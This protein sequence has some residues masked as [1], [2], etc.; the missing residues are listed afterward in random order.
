MRKILSVVIATLVAS[1]P[2]PAFPSGGPITSDYPHVAQ[3]CEKGNFG[4]LKKFLKNKALPPCLDS[5]PNFLEI[6]E[7]AQAAKEMHLENKLPRLWQEFELALA[8]AKKQYAQASDH[9]L[10]KQVLE[11]SRAARKLSNLASYEKIKNLIIAQCSYACKARAVKGQFKS[12]DGYLYGADESVKEFVN[13]KLMALNNN[14]L[15]A[16]KQGD[17]KAVK[18]Y[19]DKGATPTCRDAEGNTL[20]HL[21]V[22]SGDKELLKFVISRSPFFLLSRNN[23]GEAALHTACQQGDV[24]IVQ[25]LVR[26]M[27]DAGFSTLLTDYKNNNGDTPLHYAAEKDHLEIVK[28]FTTR[29]PE[30]AFE[31][32]GWEEEAPFDRCFANKNI[33]VPIYWLSLNPDYLTGTWTSPNNRSSPACKGFSSGDT[34]LHHAAL[35]NNLDLAQWLVERG[36]RISKKNDL[37]KTPFEVAADNDNRAIVTYFVHRGF[38]NYLPLIKKTF[39]HLNPSCTGT[40]QFLEESLTLTREL[41]KGINERNILKVRNALENGA[42]PNSADGRNCTAIGL[43]IK[44]NFQEAIEELIAYGANMKPAPGIVPALNQALYQ[45]PHNLSIIELLLKHGATA[46][47]VDGLLIALDNIDEKTEQLLAKYGFFNAQ[48]QPD[49]LLR[50]VLLGLVPTVRV[51]LQHD[52][53]PNHQDNN[54]DTALHWICEVNPEARIKMAKLLLSSGASRAIKNRRGE[55]PFDTLV[56]AWTPDDQTTLDLL[57]LLAGRSLNFGSGGSD[58]QLGEKMAIVWVYEYKGEN[59]VRAL[60]YLAARGF[61]PVRRL[62]GKRVAYQTL[63][64]LAC[65][66]QNF[67]LAAFLIEQGIDGSVMDEAGCSAFLAACAAENTAILRLLLDHG[68]GLSEFQLMR[69]I[70]EVLQDPSFDQYDPEPMAL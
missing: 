65:A 69:Q 12:L 28:F 50:A 2:R 19:L 6:T 22:L 56:D 40:K 53:N 20:I 32:E 49:L 41:L 68:I 8:Q 14:M 15:A 51:L 16:A 54:G 31:L 34:L 38:F 61:S 55:T 64:H 13:T 1:M 26:A 59:A 7:R 62:T 27:G 46:K 63:L 67:P 21:A 47:W 25:L 23:L 4:Q 35:H 29:K 42:S 57:E 37:G 11:N 58:Q 18:D 60:K 17:L 9:V 36:L 44:T 70:W 10:L 66:F 52:F 39:A 48:Q 33:K 5:K 24:T 30:S 45:K 3:L 43:A